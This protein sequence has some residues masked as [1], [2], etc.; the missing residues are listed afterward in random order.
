MNL[1]RQPSPR[2]SPTRCDGATARRVGWE[3]V[4]DLSAVAEAKAEGRA[5]AAPKW[6]RPRRRV[7][8]GS[9][10]TSPHQTALLPSN[11]QLTLWICCSL[12]AGFAGTAT[13]ATN[14][15]LPR[16]SASQA[17]VFIVQDPAATDAFKPRPNVVSAMVNR[18]I[19]N[20]TGKAATADAWRSLVS[21]Q[22]IVGIKVFSEPGPN[23]GTRRA[24]VAAVIEGLLAAGLP[25]R[26]IVVWDKHL[27]DLRLAGFFE[28]ATNYQVRIAGSAEAGYDE[29]NS[30]ST[31]LLGNLAWGDFEF[32]R[33]GDGIGRKSFVSKLLT[34]QQTKII[35]VT[36]LMNHNEA[37]V[38]GNLFSLALGS[39]DNTM[40]FESAPD[41]LATAVPEIYALP[42]LSDRVVLNIVDALICQYE[43]EERSLLHYSTV[44]NQLR[45]SRDPVALDVLSLEEL[46]RQRQLCSAPSVKTNRE[47]YSNAALLELGVSDPHRIQII[48]VP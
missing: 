12:V 19:T 26:Q 48:R 14:N 8:V 39:V 3:R 25:P 46:E 42:V 30:Y 45:F 29:T 1:P 2:P 44:L 23:S 13:A 28:L 35:N 15:L 7:R 31:P 22:D 33:T 20:L 10:E 41:R 21:T 32:G 40:R 4:S 36:P 27:V 38:C 17:R 34:Q 47:L 37:G 16:S 6:L 24:V 5:F 18:A 43:G 9:W 11:W